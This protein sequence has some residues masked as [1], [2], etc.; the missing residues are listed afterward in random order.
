M[1][2]KAATKDEAT[3]DPG[4]PRRQQRRTSPRTAEAAAVITPERLVSSRRTDTNT[5]ESRSST[6][7]H[8]TPLRVHA[9]A[10]INNLPPRFSLSQSIC[11]Y[12]YFGLAPNVWKPASDDAHEDE[13]VY[14]RPFVYGTKHREEH[15]A[16]IRVQQT[17]PTTLALTVISGDVPAT[18][19]HIEQIASHVRRVLRVDWS[20]ESFWEVHPEARRRGYGRT[21]RSPTLWEDLVKT[22]TNCNMQWS[23]TCQMNAKLCANVG[24]QRS[25]GTG[26]GPASRSSSSGDAAFPTPLQVAEKGPEYLKANCR[27]GYR[28]PWVYELSTK[29]LSGEIDSMRLEDDDLS[30]DAMYKSL[31]S[32]KGFGKFASYN[33]MQLLGRHDSFPY[34]TETTRL[35]RGQFKV[36]RSVPTSAVHKQARERY[37]KYHPHQFLAYWFDLWRNYEARRG[38]VS[39]RWTNEAC[40]AL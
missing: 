12:G 25:G 1:K 4:T 40:S 34:D 7:P 18:D 23:G 14:E 30:S 2:R 15:A 39:T 33:V 31:T 27:L 19:E 37:E 29:F 21:F 32:L 26:A 5:S 38:T 35:F 16:V 36:P 22:I 17:S 20:P 11:S 28:A 6:G 9:L 8:T 24:H 13:G 3:T 10:T